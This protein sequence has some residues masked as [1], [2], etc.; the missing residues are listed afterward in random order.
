MDYRAAVRSG[1]LFGFLTG[2]LMACM[3][4]PGVFYCTHQSEKEYHAE[5]EKSEAKP[6]RLIESLYEALGAISK[7]PSFLEGPIY[8]VTL[9][10]LLLVGPRA[11]RR[12]NPGIDTAKGGL[13]VGAWAGLVAG[14]VIFLMVGAVALSCATGPI[15]FI[16]DLHELTKPEP[17]TITGLEFSHILAQRVMGVFKGTYLGI[18]MFLG[19][20]AFLGGIG[21]AVFAKARHMIRARR[22]R[23][24]AIAEAPPGFQCVK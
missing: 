22:A 15:C 4:F 16:A 5:Q 7:V 24:T 12:S 23:K 18:S 17:K 14:N 21:G 2:M 13:I 10:P 20:G 8:I 11:V 1:L 6:N 19:G 3:A 9:I